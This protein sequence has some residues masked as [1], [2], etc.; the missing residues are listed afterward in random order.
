[1]QKIQQQTKRRKNIEAKCRRF[2]LILFFYFFQIG[3]NSCAVFCPI[4]ILR[5]RT[6]IENK[7]VLIFCQLFSTIFF[8]I[9]MNSMRVNWKSRYECVR[10]CMCTLQNMNIRNI[11]FLYPQSSEFHY[12]LCDYF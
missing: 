10:T 1:M 2:I 3:K 12:F 9:E 7:N 8:F 11:F 5:N 6:R 4:W